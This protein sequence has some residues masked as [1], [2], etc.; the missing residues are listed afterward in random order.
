MLKSV[1]RILE[2]TELPRFV[3]V[4]YAMPQQKVANI[5]QATLDALNSRG[6]SDRIVPNSRIAITAGSRC[7]SNIVEIL[8]TIVDVVREK[9]ASPYIGP[10][11]GSHGGATAEGQLEMLHGYGITQEAVGAPIISDMTTEYVG[12]TPHGLPDMP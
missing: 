9:G 10:A 3:K 6:I 12:E 7:I 8:K 2:K 11:M 4:S 5:R 1:E